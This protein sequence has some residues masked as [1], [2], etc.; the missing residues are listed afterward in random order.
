MEKNSIKKRSINWKEMKR[1]SLVKIK[2]NN[3]R[4][5]AHQIIRENLYS[6]GDNHSMFFTKE[7]IEKIYSDQ[8][9]QPYVSYEKINNQI[10]YTAIPSFLGNEKKT[11]DFAKQ[12]Q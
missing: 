10:A 11:L 6:I 7:E 12:I 4:E 1:N 9:E 3:S 8:N 5:N 2:E